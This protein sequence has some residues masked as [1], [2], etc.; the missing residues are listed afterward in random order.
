MALP[1]G[2]LDELRGR[3]S[4]ARIAER[5]LTWDRG[6]TRSN[7]GE[8]W[9][10]CP[11]HQEKSASFKIDDTS[12]RYY[13]F[14]CQAKGDAINFVME[15]GNMGFMEAVE[16][17]AAEAGLAMPARDPKVAQQARERAGLSQIMELAIRF[18]RQQIRSARAQAARAYLAG[19]GLDEDAIARF[20]I[21]FAPG[22]GNLLLEA[23]AGRGLAL[24]D[25]ETAGLITRPEDGRAPYDRFRD[26]IMFPIRDARGQAVGF[27]G[28]A[29]D[30]NAP[31]KYYNSPDTPL[32]DKGRC[33]YNHK[34][35]R[36]AAGKAGSLIV[37]EGYM[38]VIALVEAGFAH[39]VAPLGTAITAEQL[40]LMWRMTSEPVIALDG[41]RA[42]LAAGM[43]LIDRA[44]PLLQPGKSLRFALLP[45]KCDPDDVIRAKGAGAMQAVIGA[46]R[47]LIDLLW[48]RETEQHSLDTPERRAAFDETL[49]R[50]IA[51]IAHPGV[52]AHYAAELRARRRQHLTAL[53][54]SIA[55][56]R[57]AAPFPQKRWVRP[58]QPSMAARR[59]RLANPG[60]DNADLARPSE[61][62]I[63]TV[64]LR[65][66]Q[67][68][69][70]FDDAIDRATFVN[71]DLDAL[72]QAML[73]ALTDCLAEADPPAALLAI[74]SQ[75]LGQIPDDLAAG[76]PAL[77]LNRALRADAPA[78]RVRDELRDRLERLLT[79]RG[80]SA[81]AAEAA[82]SLAADETASWRLREA[83]EAR[84]KAYEA[85]DLS[86]KSATV[87]QESIDAYFNDLRARQIW[88]KKKS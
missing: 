73:T 43:R 38:D 69:A 86:A 64:C 80:L 74:L 65:H 34:P 88:V 10:C 1:D 17:L 56:R 68:A 55:P 48:Q 50:L 14:G 75:A 25:L 84:D 4:L 47:P 85:E 27:G 11:F 35:A 46:A 32:F 51:T 39:S 54:L 21:G 66:P 60:L 15:T 36:E 58:L 12:G 41:D 29:M 77:A 18:Y 26:R 63:L 62:A 59:S 37:A 44:L 6:K 57:S 82:E 79:E 20:E 9:A 71:V 42:G 40:G 28:R 49:R 19:R 5:S 76:D 33:L 78:Q 16:S 72:R 3:I 24:N 67:I 30:P 52:R 31:A 13:C 83:A 23:L 22:S 8:Y 61:L 53:Q 87:A 2:F 70:E 81:E 45:E 7:R